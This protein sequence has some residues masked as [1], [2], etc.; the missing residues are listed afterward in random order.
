MR[1]GSGQREY[2]GDKIYGARVVVFVNH[3]GLFI[4]FIVV[5]Y[6]FSFCAAIIYFFSLHSIKEKH[7]ELQQEKSQLTLSGL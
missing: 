7:S 4:C 5:G 3:R 1:L 6:K 2:V